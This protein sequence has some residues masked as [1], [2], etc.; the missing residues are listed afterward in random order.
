[1]GKWI[2]CTTAHE[3]FEFDTE[4]EALAFRY[5]TPEAF[6]HFDKVEAKPLTKTIYRV[7]DIYCTGDSFLHTE[8][9]ELADF[10]CEKLN[11][12][13]GHSHKVEQ[14]TLEVPHWDEDKDCMPDASDLGEAGTGFLSDIDGITKSD[15]IDWFGGECPVDPDTVVEYRTCSDG[16]EVQP[17]YNLRWNWLGKS[18]PRGGDITAYRVVD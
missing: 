4:A 18:G 14:I 12:K 9:K 16:E 13:L 7:Y 6:H 10:F 11:M 2:V 3:A 1:M 15:W 8:S 17:A 5:K